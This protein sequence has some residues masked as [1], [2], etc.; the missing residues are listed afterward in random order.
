MSYPAD[1]GGRFDSDT[2]RRVL[3]SLPNPDAEP[4]DTGELAGRLASDPY[5]FDEGFVDVLKDLEANGMASS[6][7]EGWVMTESGLERLNAPLPE[8]GDA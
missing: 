2:H 3:G 4:M 1:P 5:T 7:E 8:D 6:T